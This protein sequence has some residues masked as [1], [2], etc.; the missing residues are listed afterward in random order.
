[1]A[2]ELTDSLSGLHVPK[3]EGLVPGG[4]N[5]IVTIHRKTNVGH[6]VVMTSELLGRHT[7]YILLGLVEKLPG[8]E[9]LISRTRDKH[10]GVLTID[11]AGSGLQA[12]NPVIVA[13]KVSQVLKILIL[14]SFFHKFGS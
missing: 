14:L 5:A 11:G 9:G 4:G 13:G 6:K 2:S 7:H 8:H 1:M 10:G 3:A 12:S